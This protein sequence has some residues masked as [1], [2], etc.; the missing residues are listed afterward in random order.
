MPES[1]EQTDYL[2]YLAV[3]R[4]SDVSRYL[5]AIPHALA[6]NWDEPQIAN[7][8]L[9]QRRPREPVSTQPRSNAP[10]CGEPYAIKIPVSVER[11]APGSPAPHCASCVVVTSDETVRVDVE[12]LS[13]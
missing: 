5:A 13:G 12:D 11:L 1:I 4:T 3:W 10:A 6:V 8:D 7:L 9:H 2:R